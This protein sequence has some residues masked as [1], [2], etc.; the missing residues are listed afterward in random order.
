MVFFTQIAHGISASK[1]IE[2]VTV[3]LFISDC[4]GTVYFTD[5]FLQGGSIATGWTGHVSEIKWTLDG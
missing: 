2:A 3:R 5:L 4:T 1:K